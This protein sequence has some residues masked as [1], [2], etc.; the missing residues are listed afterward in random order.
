MCVEACSWKVAGTTLN[1]I[2]L[3]PHITHLNRPLVP[4][5]MELSKSKFLLKKAGL[6][7]GPGFYFLFLRRKIKSVD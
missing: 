3:I 2:C 5:K 1:H 7:K 4:G 6:S